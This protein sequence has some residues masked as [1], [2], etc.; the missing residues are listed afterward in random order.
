MVKENL[1]ITSLLICLCF[2]SLLTIFNNIDLH[3]L[4]SAS[5]IA[6]MGIIFLFRK[7]IVSDIK[8]KHEI[9]NFNFIFKIVDNYNKKN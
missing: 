6:V 5:L 4:S 8:L 7:K 3:I 9:I 1:I 2:T